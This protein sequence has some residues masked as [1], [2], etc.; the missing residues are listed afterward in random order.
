MRAVVQRV[1]RARVLVDGEVVGAID[2]G[3]CVLLSVGPR[4]DQAVA[5]RLAGRIAT[6]RIF[7]DDGGRMNLDLVAAGGSLLLVSQFTLHADTSRGHRPSFIGAAP[8][9]VASRLCDRVAASLRR[10]EISVATGRFG[11]H[12]N[13]ELT[14]DGPVTIVF[15]SGEGPWLADGG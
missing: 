12:M 6:L 1:S 9:D 11:A 13:V 2:R 8:A 14:N 7:P 15:A 4:D 5:D 3:L 10:R